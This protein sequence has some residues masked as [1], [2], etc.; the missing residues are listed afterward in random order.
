[1]SKTCKACKWFFATWQ[2]R[3]NSN[4]HGECHKHAIVRTQ[5]TQNNNGRMDAATCDGWPYVNEFEKK[6]F[7]GDFAEREEVTR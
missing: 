6:Y 7:C 5:E 3:Q 4:W 2:D 1:M